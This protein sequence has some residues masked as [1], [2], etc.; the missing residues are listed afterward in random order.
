MLQTFIFVSGTLLDTAN[1]ETV[2]RIYS[3]R[4]LLGCS[5]CP[6]CTRIL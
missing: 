1:K 2:I 6:Q 5:V 4:K 3:L